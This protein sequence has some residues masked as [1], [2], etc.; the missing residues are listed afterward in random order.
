[1]REVVVVSVETLDRKYPGTGGVS[2]GCQIKGFRRPTP[3]PQ[4]MQVPYFE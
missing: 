4:K 2:L 1:M 3:S